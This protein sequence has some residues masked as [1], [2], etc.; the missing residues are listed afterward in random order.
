ML[1]FTEADVLGWVTPILWPFLRVLALFSAL[2]VIGQAGVPVRVRIG[3]SFLIAF[4]AQASMPA[5]PVVA[6]DSA[7]AILVV[8]QQ[9]LIG[10]S[11]GF[12][13]KI[14][15]VA[16]EY[17]GEI[18]GLQM[19]LN[20]AAFFNPMSGGEETAVSRFFGISVS[21][22]FIV[23]G[24][25][26]LVI[27][28]VVQSFS[29]FPVGNDPFAFLRAVEPQ[30]WGAEIFSLG[31]WLALPLIAMLLFTNLVLGVIARVA[32]QMNIFAIGFPITLGVGLVGVLLTIPLMATPFT[33]A[34]ERMLQNFR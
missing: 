18:I 14:V 34:L 6:L 31:L 4:C 9:V 2:P 27:A 26:L 20:F 33:M 25:H 13:V 11:L 30:R 12:A 5:M 16:V 19:G 22:L 32:Q 23:S 24:G 29:A 8:L 3:L 7:A 21:W 17:A 15:F 1:T 10:L 28:A